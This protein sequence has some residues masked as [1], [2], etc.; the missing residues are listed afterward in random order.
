MF[1]SR[2]GYFTNIESKINLVEG[3]PDDSIWSPRHYFKD[4]M[5]VDLGNYSLYY[6]L[7][8]INVFIIFLV[9]HLF[10]NKLSFNMSIWQI[11]SFYQ[12][13]LKHRRFIIEAATKAVLLFPDTEKSFRLLS[14]NRSLE[15]SFE[16]CY[17]SGLVCPA[18]CVSNENVYA[19][20][21][22]QKEII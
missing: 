1:I 8:S 7:I 13:F 21:K 9:L 16:S 14:N 12:P 22:N 17:K 11:L 19:K 2:N 5:L 10:F 3:Q 6:S 4:L 15:Q 20:Y 18:E